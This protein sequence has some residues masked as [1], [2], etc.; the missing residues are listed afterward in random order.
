MLLREFRH[1]HPAWGKSQNFQW[2]QAA[3]SFCLNAVT[4]D[5]VSDPWYSAWKV[6]A[7]MNIH[8]FRHLLI[9]FCSFEEFYIIKTHQTHLIQINH[10]TL[11]TGCWGGRQADMPSHS[12]WCRQQHHN[13]VQQQYHSTA[14]QQYHTT[15][16]VSFLFVFVQKDNNSATQVIQHVKSISFG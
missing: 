9:L 8:I 1:W 3:K 16:V 2:V 10:S 6:Y 13:T 12:S 11:N 5:W 7:A 15:I 4:T 14:Q